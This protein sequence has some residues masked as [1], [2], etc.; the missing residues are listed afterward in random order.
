MLRSVNSSRNSTG[1]LG[2]NFHEPGL[3]KSQ[4][5]KSNS[6]AYVKD[7]YSWFTLESDRRQQ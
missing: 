4:L 7:F 5:A 3:D 1:S 6:W 2:L